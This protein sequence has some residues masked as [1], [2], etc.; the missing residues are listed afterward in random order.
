[1]KKT[2]V[3]K[4]ELLNSYSSPNIIIYF[5]PIPNG[6][7]PWGSPTTHFLFHRSYYISRPSFS[8]RKQKPFFREYQ[9]GLGGTGHS[10]KQATVSMY[11]TFII[12]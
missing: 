5:P 4:E 11:V 10:E 9:E 1:M 8:V 12:S 2:S 7:F 6:L 3:C